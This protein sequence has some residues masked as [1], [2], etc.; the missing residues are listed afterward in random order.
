MST[1]SENLHALNAIHIQNGKD[2]NNANEKKNKSFKI[3]MRGKKW[4]NR[5]DNQWLFCIRISISIY[6]C[7]LFNFRLENLQKI[8]FQCSFCQKTEI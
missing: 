5:S 1:K 3:S 7:Q 2:I 4:G 6:K 8:E